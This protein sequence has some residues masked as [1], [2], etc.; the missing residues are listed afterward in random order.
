VLEAMDTEKAADSLEAMDTATAAEVIEE[1]TP[2]KAADILEKVETEKAAATVETM[3][4]EKAADVIEK[5]DA[6]TAANIVEKV[7]VTKAADVVEAMNAKAAA[8]VVEK[9]EV[10]KAAD[11]I[12]A[13]AVV[14]AGDVV[15]NMVSTAA[16]NVVVVMETSSAAAILDNTDPTAGAW[17]MDILVAGGNDETAVAIADVMGDD[18]AADLLAEMAFLPSSPDKAAVI[19]AGMDLVK[20]TAVF[21]TMA[22]RGNAKAAATIFNYLST[23]RLNSILEGLTATSVSAIVAELTPETRANV[24]SELIPIEPLTPIPTPSIP[25]EGPEA[26]VATVEGDITELTV[27]IQEFREKISTAEKDVAKVTPKEG[28]QGPAGLKGELGAQGPAG[29]MG[30]PGVEGSAVPEEPAAAVSVMSYIAIAIVAIALVLSI[31]VRL[32][33][34]AEKA[35]EED[36][37]ET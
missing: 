15:E 13:M 17:V 3:T 6:E 36:I 33:F 22:Q 24:S 14:K 20:A 23:A 2:T 18:A 37:V 4:T 9:V 31:V 29:P 30:E 11:I 21:E 26:R 8:D 35:K 5:M 10:E 34:T 27:E 32:H 25:A 7:E 16:A 28:P 12:A 1:A 19:V